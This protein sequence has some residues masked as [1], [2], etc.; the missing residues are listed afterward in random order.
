MYITLSD[1]VSRP[2]LALLRAAEGSIN[3]WYY[4]QSLTWKA[5]DPGDE[6]AAGETQSMQIAEQPPKVKYTL[7]GVF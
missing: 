6:G 4:V 1:V 7:V 2:M 3:L 5:G